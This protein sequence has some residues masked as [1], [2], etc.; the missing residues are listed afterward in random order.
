M[1]M[2]SGEVAWYK[3]IEY[4]KEGKYVNYLSYNWL[5]MYGHPFPVVV[6]PSTTPR[7]GWSLTE[8]DDSPLS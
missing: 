8:F 4:D 2:S 6:V 5:I 3:I 1:W 7:M